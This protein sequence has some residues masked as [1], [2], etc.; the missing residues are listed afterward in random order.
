MRV[1]K[2][3][4]TGA[5]GFLGFN[6]I[7]SI[8]ARYDVTGFYHRNPV[9]FSKA[10]AYPLHI[11]N[12]MNVEDMLKWVKPD[13]IFHLASISNPNQCEKDPGESYASNVAGT[14]N[15]IAAA[16]KLNSGLV[17]TSSDLVFDGSSAPYKESDVPS[18]I[19]RY[20]TQKQEAE[21]AVLDYEKGK[22][23]RLPLLFGQKSPHSGSFLQPMVNFLRAKS[24]ITLFEDEF[25]T[26]ISAAKAIEGLLW[27]A[28]S[29]NKLA[30]ISCDER[31]SRYDLGIKIAG[32]LGLDPSLIIKTKQDEIKFP[33]KRPKDT[34]LDISLAKS[35]GFH[36]GSLD[37]E[38]ER[39]LMHF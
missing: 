18:P 9:E 20:G 19:S 13:I 7:N 17:F 5:S 4:V 22:V 10:S 2:V 25:R 11:N 8:S 34:S 27:I 24:K 21:N 12:Y 37:E 26:P 15:I 39:V 14:K 30:H 16:K 3:A 36:P 35:D 38:L 23:V 31:I 1:A 6:F 32:Y 33:A 28:S 29:S